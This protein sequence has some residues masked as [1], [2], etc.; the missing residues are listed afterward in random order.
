MAKTIGIIAIKGGVGKTTLS[1]SLAADLANRHQKKVLLVDANFS[2]PNLGLHMDIVQPVKTIHDVIAGKAQLLSAIH[3]RYGVDVVPGSYFFSRGINPLKLAS[4]LDNVKKDYDFV[5]VDS[6]PALN[7][8]TLSAIHASDNLFVVSTPD[9][10][11]LS[12]SLRAAKLSK[13][14]G[15]PVTGLILNK[16]RDPKYEITLEEMEKTLDIP[17]VARIPDDKSNVRALFMRIPQTLYNPNSPFSR[18]V[19]R[20][21]D[22]LVGKKQNLSFFRRLFAPRLRKEEV[23]RQLLKQDLYKSIFHKKN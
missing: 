9:Y 20:L 3:K 12:C 6:S 5:V 8:E 15:K 14:K 1:A 10:P 18:E 7:D 16:I 2:A 22:A 21:S 11:T 4:R 17:V 19:G 23:N 13:E